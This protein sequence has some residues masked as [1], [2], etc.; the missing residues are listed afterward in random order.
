MSTRTLNHLLEPFA[1]FLANPD[2][3][4]L[5]V[6]RIG[7][8]GAEVA[9]DWHWVKEPA[10]T[11]D[12]LDAIGILAAFNSGQDISPTH[13]LCDTSLPNGERIN[14]GRPPATRDIICLSIRKPLSIKATVGHMATSGM[15]EDY[16]PM[17]P[18]QLTE[19]TELEMDSDL[20][21]KLTQGVLNRKNILIAGATGTRKT[22]LA[23]ALASCIP[24]DERIITIED[25]AE[26]DLP[27]HNRVAFF[28]SQGDQG[29]AKIRSEALL[30]AS[31]RMRPDRVLMGEVRGGAAFAYLRGAVAGHPGCIT[32][33]HASSAKGAF[34]ALR[35]MARQHPDGKTMGDKDI[36]D[37]FTD[38]VD[39][40]VHCQKDP[41]TKRYW[42]DDVWEK[43][44]S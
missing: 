35:L 27:H 38:T 9:G 18:E 2:T 42:I 39:I 32:T 8:F 29:L 20:A 25:T 7:E 16:K 10:L 34:N 33:L 24:L 6:N 4:D 26:L 21:V 37:L 43:G 44:M 41:Q 5:V 40:V 23:N 36:Y 13:P 1:P 3:T 31:L 12:A 22:T 14:I 15:F 17:K 28:Y 30:E 11:F 19:T